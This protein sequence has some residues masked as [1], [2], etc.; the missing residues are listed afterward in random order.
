MIGALGAGAIVQRLHSL[1][2]SYRARN[3]VMVQ[4]VY[5]L[6]KPVNQQQIL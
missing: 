1:Q 5:L 2:L 6:P 4:G 3:E